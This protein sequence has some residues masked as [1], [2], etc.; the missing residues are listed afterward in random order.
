MKPVEL[1]RRCLANSSVPG[2]AVLD[3]FCGSGSTLI[4]CHILG[5]RGFGMEID[6]R[7]ADVAVARFEELTGIEARREEGG[8]AG[9][10]AA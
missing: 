8:P 4:A 7:Y 3:P 9:A 10:E 1:V 6:P 2:E 5:R